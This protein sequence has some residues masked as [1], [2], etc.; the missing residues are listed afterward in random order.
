MYIIAWKEQTP[1][2]WV[3]QHEPHAWGIEFTVQ[4]MRGLKIS[5]SGTV[6]LFWRFTLALS[7]SSSSQKAS[8]SSGKQKVSWSRWSEGLKILEF[9]SHRV[10]QHVYWLVLAFQMHPGCVCVCFN[11]YRKASRVSG[12]SQKGEKILF[13]Q[14][15]ENSKWGL[16]CWQIRYGG[17]WMM[18]RWWWMMKGDVHHLKEEPIL[19][20]KSKTCIQGIQLYSK[21]DFLYRNQLGT[22]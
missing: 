18:K 13:W 22:E 3:T 8:S 12:V 9:V 1:F 7:K 2:V 19:L 14:D 20:Q 15:G 21:W 11:G 6:L 5:V 17:W 16:Y 10:R 4:W